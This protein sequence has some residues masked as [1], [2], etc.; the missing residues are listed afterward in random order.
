MKTKA[1]ILYLEDDILDEEL[2]RTM[3]INE[4]SKCKITSVSTK[5]DFTYSL[6]NFHIDLILADYDLPDFNGF[7]AL[8]ITRK[9]YPNIPFIYITGRISEDEAIEAIKAGATDYV[10]KDK[11]GK[12]IPAVKRALKEV[13]ESKNIKEIEKKLMVSNELFKF[14]IEE[15]NDGITIINQKGVVIS[16]NNSMEMITG[17]KQK[18]AMH[19]Y[20]WDIQYHFAPDEIK[21]EVFYNNIKGKIKE[22]LING[23]AQWLNRT[24]EFKIIDATNKYKNIE[25]VSSLI[26]TEGEIFIVAKMRDITEK[27]VSEEML[28]IKDYALESSTN[29]I[30]LTDLKVIITYAN[31]EALNILGYNNK[32]DLIGKSTTSF[33]LFGINTT[34][35]IGIIFNKEKWEGEINLRKADGKIIDL[36]IFSSLVKD[37]AERPICII[38]TFYDITERK[39]VERELINNE[40]IYKG[41]FEFSNNAIFI[42]DLEGNI[43][44]ANK[45]ASNLLG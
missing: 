16:W 36:H 27:R 6:K 42:Y 20:I 43:L 10:F 13:N 7:S 34:N 2:I 40:A 8:K 15:L 39:K 4:C 33:S 28:M 45:K 24:S 32:S 38:I 37:I 17:I 23:D 26:R 21:N 3:L 14:I 5:K 18:E 44:D 11:L 19:R 9:I 1:Q 30:L 25:S 41:L 22:A 12:L 35:I 31:K 29:G